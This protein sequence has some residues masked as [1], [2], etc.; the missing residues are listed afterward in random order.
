MT[1]VPIE[2][3]ESEARRNAMLLTVASAF[4]GSGPSIVISLGGLAGTYLLGPDKSLATLPVS[5]FILGG[6]V[7]AAPAA[8]L[9]ARIGRRAGFI[10]GSLV[11][12]LGGIAAGFA[13]LA[14]S[15]L[16]FTLA[17][18]VTGMA[19]AFTQQYRFA[20]ADS[21]SP[22]LRAKAISWVMVGGI[23]AAILGPQS[24]ILTRHW[25]DPIPFAG[26]YFAMAALFLAGAAALFFLSGA[27]RRPP[28]KSTSGGGG[29]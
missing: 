3:E 26:S 8:M 14:E 4:S 25:F 27:A 15:F 19:G 17:L 29:R 21:G 22:A 20:A 28:P 24:M 23:A 10:W 13:V 1:S 5:F 2:A 18:T 7:A 9:M 6:A 16:L 11:G 12:A